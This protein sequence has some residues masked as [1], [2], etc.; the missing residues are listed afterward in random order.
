[1]E[2]RQRGKRTVAAYTPVIARVDVVLILGQDCCA[3]LQKTHRCSSAVQQCAHTSY[4]SE[5]EDWIISTN[6]TGQS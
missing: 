1:M 5:T 3:S 6:V 2:L 4:R